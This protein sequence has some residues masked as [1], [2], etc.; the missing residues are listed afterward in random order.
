[1]IITPISEI[2]GKDLIIDYD[3][4]NNEIKCIGKDDEIIKLNTN[5]FEENEF[6]DF[7]KS[8]NSNED[9]LDENIINEYIDFAEKN[10]PNKKV[11]RD[12]FQNELRDIYLNLS[13]Y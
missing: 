2:L 10:N 9:D 7:I 13:I 4:S 6:D 5:L 3:N 8:N 11:L 12:Y 1:M